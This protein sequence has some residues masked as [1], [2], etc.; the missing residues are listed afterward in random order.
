MFAEFILL[1]ASHSV[2]EWAERGI[3]IAVIA[4]VSLMHWLVPKTGVRIMNLISSFEIIILLFVV[5][6]GWVVLSGRVNKT[7]DPHASFRNSCVGSSHSGHEHATALFKVLNS[8]EGLV[9]D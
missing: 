4:F 8:Y 1:V 2:T 7:K 5:I 6:T 9:Y 3:A